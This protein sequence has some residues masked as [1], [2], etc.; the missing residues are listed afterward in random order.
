MSSSDTDTFRFELITVI[1]N[2]GQASKVLTKAES[3]GITGGTIFLGMGTISNKILEFFELTDV[4]KEIIFMV[5]DEKTSHEAMEVISKEFAFHKPNHGIACVMPLDNFIDSE[6]CKYINTKN[7]E[8]DKNKAVNGTMYSTIF[9]IVE[10]GKAEYVVEA[11]KAVG[12][13]G[14]TVMHA[15]G[16]G[17]HENNKLFNMPI[18][19]EK[20]IVIII[21]E[22]NIVEAIASSIGEKIKIDESGNGV[23]FT[24]PVS[25]TYGL[26]QERNNP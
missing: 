1:V 12:A 23:I 5:A 4:R 19:P 10:R 17:I 14:A 11:A 22:N 8:K 2:F 26:Y 6:H 24:M 7:T 21:A 15:R 20:E 13:K 16:S 3:N 9:T 25:K 18:E